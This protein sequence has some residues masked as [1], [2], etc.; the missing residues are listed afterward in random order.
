M[1]L[2]PRFVVLLFGALWIACALNAQKME[3]AALPVQDEAEL[4]PVTEA[5]E[6]DAAAETAADT[7]PAVKADS[8]KSEEL[9]EPAPEATASF[10][11]PKPALREL[12]TASGA[13]DVYVIPIE[14]PISK[15]NL[16]ILRRGLKEA[17]NNDVEM[18]VLDMD[19]PGGRVDICLEMMEMLDRFD[20][21]T[22]TYVNE[23]AISAGSFIA[24]AT[25]EIYFAPRG[26]I[27]A[28]A[29]IQG[30]GED[31][32]ETAKQKIESYLRASIRVISEEDPLRGKVIR[33]M[34]DSDF[35][36]KVGDTVI[37]PA[38][39]L[40][41]LTASEAVAEYGDPPRKLLGEGVYENIDELLKARVGDDRFVVRDFHISYSED[42]AKWMDGF[43]PALI[44]IG[45]LLLFIEFKTPG[46]GIFG[47]LGIVMIA[48]FFISQSIAG[49]AGN[50]T[51][52]I[53]V[54]GVVL[55]LIELVFFPG[56]LLFA[57]PGIAMMLGSLL[58]AMVD[59]WPKGT[60]E[61]T[62]D[63]FAEPM[64]NL[65]FGMGI[66]VFGA[67]L[68]SRFV[69]G[70]ALESALVLS[71]SAGGAASK[72]DNRIAREHHL[73]RIGLVGSALT[74]MTPSGRVELGGKR[75]E[76]RCAVGMIERGAKI[77]VARYEDF[78]V[79]V[80][81]VTE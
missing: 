43:A 23:D 37:K 53:F 38:G 56:M 25:D 2:T 17:I 71:G 6:T 7:E 52:V 73:P 44:G 40:L 63:M 78:D 74:Q 59:Y 18:V 31:V 13:I 50:E 47:I 65:V 12:D 60:G 51:I 46:F 70:S 75:Y 16:F 67:I 3:P 9:G 4:L 48:V 61:L 68:V 24:A 34:L 20:G 80:E 57:V 11:Y 45:M 8:G 81:E 42:I 77:R 27:G 66:A 54:L 79:V 33:A 30:T 64:I 58:W 41:T 14:G 5:E 32:P 1:L 28:S 55:V 29:V 36:L 10:H 49:L 62:V 39:E 35:E 21:L 26:K 15:P 72:E 76:A 69:K 22:A 19:T